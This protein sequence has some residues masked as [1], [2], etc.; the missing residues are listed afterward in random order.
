MT[1]ERPDDLLLPAIPSAV[2]V[3]D[4]SP[5]DLP[6]LLAVLRRTHEQEGYPVR[7]GAVDAE[8]LATTSELA[9]G[10][11]V[12][13]SRVVGHVAL[14]PADDPPD[15]PA[16]RLWQQATARGPEGLAV[17]SRLFTDR[18]VRGAGT[19]L[20]EHAVRQA[21]ELGRAAVLLVDPD[22]PARAFYL[23]RGWREVGSATQQ[24][25]PRTVDAALLVHPA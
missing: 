25:G 1:S 6:A 7:A 8:W 20:L 2:A 11:A 18:S 3:R 24:W 13:G 16:L 12:H 15:S 23:R 19:A 22:S 4:R 21:A 5:A 17:V 9:N 10:V 14:H